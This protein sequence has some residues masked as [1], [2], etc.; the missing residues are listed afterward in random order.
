MELG[1][2][3]D[4]MPFLIRDATPRPLSGDACPLTALVAEPHQVW[5]PLRLF[6]YLTASHH[7]APMHALLCPPL[8]VV[9]ETE[10][11]GSPR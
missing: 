10:I 4:S 9:T 2:R 6:T 5:T 3:M 8:G 11:K 1:E 7:L